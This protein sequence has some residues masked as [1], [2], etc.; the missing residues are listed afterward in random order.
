MDPQSLEPVIGLG[1]QPAQVKRKHLDALFQ[2]QGFDD[3]FVHG[4]EH[5]SVRRDGYP[6]QYLGDFVLAVKLKNVRKAYEVIERAR[7]R[8][9]ADTLRDQK[10]DPPITDPVTVAAQKH[11]N[12]IQ[13]TLLHEMRPRKREELLEQLFETEQVFTPVEG[14]KKGF[15]AA[16]RRGNVVSL[17][18]L[19]NQ[20]HADE[21]VLEYVLDEPRSFCIRI[22]RDAAEIFALPEGRDAIE[23]LGQCA[24][25]RDRRED[26][27]EQVALGPGAPCDDRRD[28]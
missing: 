21:V 19:Q 17:L 8:S 28:A 3:I 25:G 18:D 27:I 5:G 15:R 4:N 13:L 23:H 12:S 9:L 24:G 14:P 7:G 2:A 11:I 20:I 26:L 6:R 22:T 10:V 16:L 1:S